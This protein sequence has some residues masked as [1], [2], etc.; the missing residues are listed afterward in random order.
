MIREG[1][2]HFQGLVANARTMHTLWCGL[3]CVGVR[4]CAP[5]QTILGPPSSGQA[6]RA[7]IRT[8]PG[9]PS[10]GSA[11]RAPVQTIYK[12]VPTVPTRFTPVQTIFKPV[13]TGPTRFTP[14]QTIGAHVSSEPTPYPSERSHQHAKRSNH[15]LTY[16]ETINAFFALSHQTKPHVTKH[17]PLN[18][19]EASLKSATC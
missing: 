5:I 18:L 4:R 10:S 8:I 11:P 6:L 2:W 1:W 12:P 3:A 17:A 7:P 19:L 14:I 13:P 15:T 9:P 16:G